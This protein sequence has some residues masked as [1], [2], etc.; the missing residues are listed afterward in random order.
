MNSL[1]LDKAER[2]TLLADIARANY[3]LDKQQTAEAQIIVD[4]L[5]K[6]PVATADIHE[7][8]GHLCSRVDDYAHAIEHTVQ[9]LELNPNNVLCM[10]RLVLL[11]TATSQLV[12][13][14]EW[15]LRATAQDSGCYEV[16][17]AQSVFGLVCD[18]YQRTAEW[19]EKA[20]KKKP[21]SLFAHL[22][23][24]V[25]M[26]QLGELDKAMEH[27]EAARRAAPK[28]VQ[29]YLNLA[30][31]QIFMGRKDEALKQ[32]Q[33]ALDIDPLCGSAL[34]QLASLKKW[35]K[36]D[37]PFIEKTEALQQQAMTVRNR[38][39]L[40]FALGKMF[41]D[42][43]DYERAFS[44]FSKANIYGKPS[45]ERPFDKKLIEREKALCTKKYLASVSAEDTSETPVFII[46]MPRSGT[47]LLEQIIA[48]H[49]QA[50]GAGELQEMV[51]LTRKLFE[52]ENYCASGF[53]S[54][55]P[56][57]T[58]LDELR[59]EY[60]SVLCRHRETAIRITDKMPENFNMLGTIALLFPKA[61]IIHVRRHPLDTCL[62]CYF[63]MFDQV[64][65][66]YELE[67]IAKAYR[68]YRKT[69]AYWQ[70]TLPSGRMIDV[71]YENLIANPEGEVRRI[72]VHIGLPW[73]PAC[74]DFSSAK[75]NVRTVSALQVR[76]PIYQTSRQRWINY[77]PHIGELANHLA[78]FLQDDR[79][80]LAEQG[81]A[82][83]KRGWLG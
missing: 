62:S 37:L 24:S 29:P 31:I 78:D 55:L 7:A 66:S 47:S 74:L 20:L 25:A 3:L 11:L 53:R 32:V 64:Y 67:W 23:L 15:L 51:Q 54:K 73:D 43:G 28:D 58:T 46:G 5:L 19:A 72:L 10:T 36:T 26:A 81:I 49:P 60:L 34:E 6:Q 70:K 39:Y 16:C 17:H 56:D 33:K 30:K 44:H 68:R 83:R 79:S 22:N 18:D 41:D 38:G 82:L 80:V 12:S 9:A 8:L 40:H 50:A 59:K 35:Q 1:S 14:R 61:R 4:R 13:A 57:R 21:H 42:I 69:I 45:V 52:Q 76:Q 77:A 63:Q 75:H 48:S 2:E 71:D 65:W 27:A